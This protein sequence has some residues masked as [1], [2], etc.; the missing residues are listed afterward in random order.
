MMLLPLKL[1][2]EIK[3]IEGYHIGKANFISIGL[4]EKVI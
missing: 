4:Y 2:I 3:Y 1:S